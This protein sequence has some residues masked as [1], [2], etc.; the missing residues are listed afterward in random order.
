MALGAEARIDRARQLLLEAMFDVGR[1]DAALDAVAGACDAR[2][3]Q[4]LALNGDNEV[5]GHFLTGVP[6]GFTQ[7]IE[8][9]GFANPVANPRFR[10][11]VSAPVMVP[12]ADQDYAGPDERKRSPIYVEIYDPHDL[13]FNCQAV[14]MRDENAFVRASVTRTRKQGPLDTRA[15]RTF[16]TL[17]PHLHAAVRVQTSLLAA[18]SAA[19]LRTLDAVGAAAFLVSERGHVVGVSHAAEALA[20]K[21]VSLQVTRGRIRLRAP[22]D[23]AAY[24]AALARVLDAARAG[25]SVTPAPIALT[26]ESVVLDVQGLPRERVCFGGAPAAIVLV[27]PAREQ[28]LA[29]VLQ[30]KFRLT[31][32]ETEVALALADGYELE[33]IAAC[34]GAAV[35]TVRSQ[36]QSIYAKMDVHRQAELVSVIRRLCGDG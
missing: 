23:Q 22:S 17:M 18:S 1:W 13:P 19:S 21:G 26:T 36:V 30:R 8:N 35:A 27:R 7:M 29:L 14:L 28:E 24:D 11:G 32:A 25:T 12:I 31:G 10:A 5:V 4:L 2:A 9:W 33:A 6:D 20:M 15:L 34:R 16:T 3:G